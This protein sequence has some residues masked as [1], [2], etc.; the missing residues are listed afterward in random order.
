MGQGGQIQ[1]GDA[2]SS[3]WIGITEGLANTYT[4]QDFI[5]IYFRNSM[6]FFSNNN[7]ERIRFSSDGDMTFYN[8]NI[9]G[10]SSH[11]MEIGDITNGAIK[12]IRMRQGGEIHFGDTTTSNF[13]GIT[14]GTVN[15]FTDVDNIG[16]YYRNSLKFFSNNNTE[17]LVMDSS[18]HIRPAS[19]N[20]SDLGAT[21]Y[22]WRNIYTN[23]L[24]LSNE[25]NSNEVDGT[26][27][28]YTIQE[29]EHDL[30]LINRRSGKR[31]KFN[32]T[33]VS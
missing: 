3:N 33:E 24:Q 11:T 4:D 22:R 17:R 32:L 12:R 1:I 7:N 9:I 31:Y 16:F 27:G 26:W 20:N 2:T 8:G 14:E 21:A 6:R 18:G 25:G 5:S 28:K 30:F 29:G 23:D 15:Q 19:N 13:M 10:N